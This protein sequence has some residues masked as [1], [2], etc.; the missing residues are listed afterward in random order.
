MTTR[1]ATVALI[2]PDYDDAIAFF[3]ET[4]GFVLVSDTTLGVGKRWVVVAPAGC[5]GAHLLLARAEGEEQ[6]AS[7]GQQGGGRVFLFLETDDFWSDHRLFSARGLHFIEKPR[8]EPYG[9]VAVFQDPF[10]NKWDLIEPKKLADVDTP[11]Q[12]EK[13]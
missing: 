8:L 5:N 13:P 1:V 9:T 11:T 2:V 7:I 4:L 6:R 12:G 3:R 10:G